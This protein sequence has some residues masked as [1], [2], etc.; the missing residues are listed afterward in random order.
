MSTDEELAAVLERVTD[1]AATARP[2]LEELTASY[3][4]L[5]KELRE[6]WGAV[7]VADAVAEHHSH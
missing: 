5:A 3:P 4:H 6:V 7:M 1:A 2:T